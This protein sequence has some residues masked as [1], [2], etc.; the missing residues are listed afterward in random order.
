M[1]S[2]SLVIPISSR[3]S[4]YYKVFNCNAF[5]KHFKILLIPKT[6]FV[7]FLNKIFSAVVS[8]YLQKINRQSAY[9][10]VKKRP[11]SKFYRKATVT[12]TC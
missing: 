11:F 7:F 10:I 9:C 3:Y 8:F 1:K 5:P 12:K 4:R 6:C 2:Y